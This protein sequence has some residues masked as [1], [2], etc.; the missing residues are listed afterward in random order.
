MQLPKHIKIIIWDGYWTRQDAIDNPDKLFLFGGNL[1]QDFIQKEPLIPK[2][3]QAVIRKL[4]NAIPVCTKWTSGTNEAAYFSD[5]DLEQFEGYLGV[6]Y[7]SFFCPIKYN[8]YDT[9]VLPS[10]ENGIGTGTAYLKEK[11]PKCWELLQEFLAP[12]YERAEKTK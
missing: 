6:S 5:K 9:I 2:V 8:G 3:T 4:P 7:N 12:L 11:A 10:K 1:I